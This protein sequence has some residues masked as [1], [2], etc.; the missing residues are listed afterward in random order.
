MEASN[1]V[2]NLEGLISAKESDIEQI[3]RDI[4]IVKEQI[5]A[6]RVDNVEG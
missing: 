5:E 6:Q 1:T 3:K 2:K 4:D